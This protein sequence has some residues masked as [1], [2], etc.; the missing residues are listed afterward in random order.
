MKK[1]FLLPATLVFIAACTSNDQK[2]N[3]TENSKTVVKSQ[4]DTTS[5]TGILSGE[6]EVTDYKKDNVKIDLP[7]TTV[8]FT[9][10]GDF[11]KGDGTRLLYTIQEDS[12]AIK[13]SEQEVITKSKIKFLSADRSAFILINPVE[14]T[15]STYKKIN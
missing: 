6:F 15:E 1:Y 7:K 9:R 13:I 12:L 2:S 3:S 8:L 5:G 14:K 10:K 4:P 11:I